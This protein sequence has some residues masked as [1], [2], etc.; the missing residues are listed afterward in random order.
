MDQDDEFYLVLPSNSSMQY[1]DNTTTK[2][3]TQLDREIN[4]IGRWVVGIAEIHI[5]ETVIHF[6]KYESFF[7]FLQDPKSEPN[8]IQ[9]NLHEIKYE[10]PHGYFENVDD[11][12]AGINSSKNILKHQ[13]LVKPSRDGGF[14]SLLRTCDCK[15]PHRTYFN[16]KTVQVLGFNETVIDE[17]GKIYIETNNTRRLIE[18][19]NPPCISRAIPK[20]LFIYSDI[21]IPYNVGDTRSSLLRIASLNMSNYLF[22]NLNVQYFTRIHYLPILKNS[23]RNICIDIRDQFGK[24]ISFQFGTVNVTLHFKR[25]R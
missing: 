16:R 5:P 24:P 25:E 20:Q 11:F 6:Q 4:L 9:N 18:A 19:N 13:K 12:A 21:C 1:F 3:T 22:G 2:F 23:F 7:I 14:W 8:K 15:L 17:N 10:F